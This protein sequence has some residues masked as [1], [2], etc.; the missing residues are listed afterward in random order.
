MIQITFTNGQAPEH[1][2]T[3]TRQGDWIIYRCPLCPDYERRIN[4]RTDQMTICGKNEYRHAGSFSGTDNMDAL[5]H[6]HKSQKN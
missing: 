6:V 3:A 2:C 1:I 5:K 4:L